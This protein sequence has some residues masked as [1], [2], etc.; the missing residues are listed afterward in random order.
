MTVKPS[1]FQKALA[2]SVHLLTSLGI[3]AGFMALLSTQSH[4]WRRAMIWLV[5]ALIIDGVDGFFARLFRVKETLP[6]ING[7]NIDYV[8][9]FV[10]YA[11]IPAFMFYEAALVP[12]EWN[13]PLSIGILLVSSLYYGRNEM[14]TADNYFIGFPV[15]WNMVM[16]Y[17]IFISDFASF[18]YIWITILICTLHF[19]PI[20]MAYPSQNHRMRLPT[21]FVFLLFLVTMVLAIYY[22]PVKLVWIAVL[23]YGVLAYFSMLMIYD[24]FVR[25]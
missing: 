1:I 9:D 8:V 6:F 16:F 2:W 4:D 18:H 25:N 20:K 12:H 15:L 21:F 23:A 17:Y 24:T 19:I 3:V 13:L 5:V 14:V 11:F 22:Y 7:Q 10:N